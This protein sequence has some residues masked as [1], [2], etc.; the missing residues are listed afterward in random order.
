MGL[1]HEVTVGGC[2]EP[3]R[4][5]ARV[6]VYVGVCSSQQLYLIPRAAISSSGIL[7]SIS[8]PAALSAT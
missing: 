3:G 1:A 8:V 7:Q 6:L 2:P 4:E 5:I